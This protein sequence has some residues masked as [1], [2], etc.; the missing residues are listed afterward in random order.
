MKQKFNLSPKINQAFWGNI[1]C[2]GFEPNTFCLDQNFNK[3]F[4]P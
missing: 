1:K 4:K 3:G 2:L